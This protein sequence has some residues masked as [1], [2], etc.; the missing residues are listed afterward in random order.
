VEKCIG[1]MHFS[2]ENT[3]GWPI[4]RDCRTP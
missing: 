2:T 4:E 3:L 1:S